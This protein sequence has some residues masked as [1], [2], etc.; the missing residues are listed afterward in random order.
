M[1]PLELA[2][3]YQVFQNGG[4]S[5]TPYLVDSVS[6]TQGRALYAH[7]GV[8]TARVL[9]PLFASRMV[10]MLEGV[11]RGGTGAGAA[12][13]RPA[14]GKT[15]TSQRWRDAWFVGFTP[16]LLAAVWL[17]NDGG[18]PMNKVTG[19]EIPAAIWKRFMSSAEAGKPSLDFAWLQQEPSEPPPDSS[20]PD[21]TDGPNF[22]DEPPG[23]GGDGASPLDDSDSRRLPPAIDQDEDARERA[24]DREP[25]SKG[26]PTATG[27]ERDPLPTTPPS[28]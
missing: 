25:P 28:F 27:D 26:P 22:L 3:A 23:A 11:V 12:I 13:G 18:G 8:P 5:T 20:T 6:D 17:G 9:D 2:A 4:V 16:D 15:G 14:A 21:M 1:T 10:R 24:L 7:L 19:G